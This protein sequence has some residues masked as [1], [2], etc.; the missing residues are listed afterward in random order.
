MTT[1][2]AASQRTNRAGLW[3]LG[4]FCSLLIAP[5]SLSAAERV[6]THSEAVPKIGADGLIVYCYGPDWN[7]RS[8]RMLDSFWAR[9]DL[10]PAAGEAILL[11]VPYYEKAPTAEELG[12]NVISP[13]QVRGSLPKPPF[14]VCPAV[15][16]FDSEGR[17]Y[18]TLIGTDGLGDETGSAGIENI[19]K[20]LELLRKRDDLMKKAKAMPAGIER[21]K[22]L[23][24]ASQLGITPPQGVEAML[25]ESEDPESKKMIAY[26]KHDALKFMYEQLDTTD[27]FLK[28]D[29]I[30]DVSAIRRASTEIF[31]DENYRPIDRQAAYN[32]Y[33]G[34]MRRDGT[35]GSRLRTP[36]RNNMKVDEET[37]YG[38]AMA[39]LVK[40]WGE[41]DRIRKT[42]EQKKALRD[43][44]RSNKAKERNQD[45]VSD[46]V[47]FD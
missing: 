43:K 10:I 40:E 30:E 8:V 32:L 37:L 14:D 26:F 20:N 16:M 33:L 36:I 35:A 42:S 5:L 19:K 9:P 39:G 31:K 15:M 25:N 38:K 7:R 17:L 28:E 18:A 4:L 1:A 24:E 2:R 23:V 41:M 44:E 47:S 12:E 34:A 45:R 46:K 3:A 21:S 29:F 6:E 13:A 27:G 22:L 11:S